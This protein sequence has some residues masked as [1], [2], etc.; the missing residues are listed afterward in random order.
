MKIST[1]IPKIYSKIHEKFG[2]NW[3]DGLAITYG[4]TVYAKFPLAP[5]VAVHETIHIEQQKI[6]ADEWWKNY[7]ES[8]QFRFDQE[9]PA[10]QAQVKFLRLKIKD[11]NQL[12]QSITKLAKDLSGPM[13]GNLCSLDF[14]RKLISSNGT[15]IPYLRIEKPKG[16]SFPRLQV[17][18]KM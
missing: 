6:G 12:F 18:A 16:R 3:D 7:M 15:Y 4:D 1:D 9:V 13:Y 17:T 2:V 8:E 10:Y 5:D 11:R 14:A